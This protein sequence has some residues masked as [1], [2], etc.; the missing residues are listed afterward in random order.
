[1]IAPS[2]YFVVVFFFRQISVL[3]VGSTASLSNDA[4]LLVCRTREK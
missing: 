3:A 4:F 2:T 1:L